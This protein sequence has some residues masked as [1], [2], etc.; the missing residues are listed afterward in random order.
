MEERT[1]IKVYVKT[2]RLIRRI[3][4]LRD[5]SMVQALQDI[6]QAEWDRLAAQ[7]SPEDSR[8]EDPPGDRESAPRQ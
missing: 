8:R 1:T 2:R 7:D 4:A 3:A 5:Q 6:C